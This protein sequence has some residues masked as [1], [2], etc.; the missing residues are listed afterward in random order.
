MEQP[1]KSAQRPERAHW[2]ECAAGVWKWARQS[3]TEARV[4]RLG[5]EAGSRARGSRET[6]PDGTRPCRRP[7]QGESATRGTEGL[8][9]VY[10]TSLESPYPMVVGSSGPNSSMR[11]RPAES[12]PAIHSRKRHALGC[13]L[14]SR[15]DDTRP[16]GRPVHCKP[17]HPNL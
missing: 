17:Y 13:S 11:G 16:P 12:T 7:T 2:L 14:R 10:R 5:L 9:C 1:L 15:W 6:R 3:A 4:S 8:L